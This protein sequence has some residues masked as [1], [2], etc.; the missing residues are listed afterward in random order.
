MTMVEVTSNDSI[1][2][3]AELLSY[4][5]N[6]MALRLFTA[7]QRKRLNVLIDVTR[8]PL[9][10]PVTRAMLAR[11]KAVFGTRAPTCFEMTVS[12]AAG[13][14]DAAE[15]LAHEMLHISQAVN[16]RLLISSR[17][18][19]FDG[20]KTRVEVARWMGGKPVVMDS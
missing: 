20:Q 4:A 13:I 17:K 10:V 11:Q 8:H 6:Y 12:T 3:E 7:R 19:R 2:G 16:E 18:T 1:P 15:T 9:R 14:R 5:A